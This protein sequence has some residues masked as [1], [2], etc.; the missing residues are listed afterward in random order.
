[1]AKDKT[2]V[3]KYKESLSRLRHVVIME[4][5]WGGTM[6]TK[7]SEGLGVGRAEREAKSIG[8]NRQ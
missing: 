1:M 8:G 3:T 4:K 5:D 6:K 7:F 2:N